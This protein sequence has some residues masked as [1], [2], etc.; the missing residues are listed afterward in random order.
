M[1]Y[2]ASQVKAEN[3]KSP[4]DFKVTESDGRGILILALPNHRDDLRAIEPKLPGT[5]RTATCWL[6]TAAKLYQPRSPAGSL[7]EPG[8]AWRAL[9]GR[10]SRRTT[11][12]PGQGWSC[13]RATR[14]G[15]S[16]KI[17]AVEPI[18]VDRY[19]IVQVQTDAGI[20][21]LGQVRGLG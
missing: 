19:M 21:G 7:K 2:P 11:L 8:W 13:D 3:V 16:M 20:S 1:R 6:R 12:L 18:M 5:A 9:V 15:C 14:K 4:D 10:A 17:T